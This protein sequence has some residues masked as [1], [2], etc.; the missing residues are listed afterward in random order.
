MKNICPQNQI[1]VASFS[2]KVD[3]FYRKS[4][5]FYHKTTQLVKIT[6]PVR[7]VVDPV[8]IRKKSK[9]RKQ[10]PNRNVNR[11]EICLAKKKNEIDEYPFSATLHLETQDIK[12]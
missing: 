11:K 2:F 8:T 3:I 9:C 6:K 12:T 1:T 10:M 5:F 7:K 4:A